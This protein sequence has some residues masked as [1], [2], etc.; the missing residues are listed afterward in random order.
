MSDK[1]I[2]AEALRL[3]S[4]NIAVI[5]V[6]GIRDGRCTCGRNPCPTNKP[7]KH[8]IYELSSWKVLATTNID[9]IRGWFIQYPDSNLAIPCEHNKLII[10]DFDDADVFEKLLNEHPEW[11]IGAWIEKTGKGFH[12]YV[13]QPKTPLL[14]GFNSKN[15]E[16]KV[17]GYTVCAP[18]LHISGK[19][20]QWLPG[21]APGINE[22][23][24][25]P[26]ALLEWLKP[27]RAIIGNLKPMKG[28][29]E[30]SLDQS[31]HATIEDKRH[32]ALWL[33]VY[34]RKA[35]ATKLRTYNAYGLGR[36]LYAA[37]VPYSYALTIADTYADIVNASGMKDTIFP[38]SK[39]REEITNAY[40]APRLDPPKRR[41]P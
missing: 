2:L 24:E 8:P 17:L 14:T 13:R 36:Q 32:A 27:E 29:E 10:I 11:F 37:G 16:V 6:H 12:V 21:H 34:V 4:L 38:R 31:R 22:L 19:R 28:G 30:S 39:S 23:K 40:R 1:I 20:Y 5:P 41:T 33:T 3:A 9:V 25:I 15:I 35:L 18:S 7:G 26:E